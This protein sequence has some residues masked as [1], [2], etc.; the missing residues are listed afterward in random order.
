MIGTVAALGEGVSRD[1]HGK[2]LEVG[3][4]V[5]FGYFTHCGHCPGCLRGRHVACEHITMA[6]AG[7]AKAWPYFVGG[8]AD[9][10]YLQPGSPIYIVPEGLPDEVVAG[11]NCALSQVIY[12]LQRGALAFDETVVIQGAGGLGLYATA[13]AKAMGSGQVIVIDGVS[14]RLDLAL[15]FGADAV[16]DLREHKD[17]N[18]SAKAVR[19]LTAGRGADL[20]LELVGDPAVVPEGIRM[21]GQMG[22]Y[23]EIG[24]ISQGR[25]YEADPSRLVVANK[26]IIGVSLYE[27][28]ILGQA[29]HFLERMKDRLPLDALVSTRFSL[30]DINQAFAA[31]EAREVIRASIVP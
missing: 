1:A 22:R 11:A 25:T 27:P 4:R 3:S 24:N 31:A 9:Y 29:L 5:T 8:Y 15:R 2:P 28:H 23:V 6:M 10:F 14:S 7:K 16:V 13:V 26:S 30:F 19:A 17:S 20:V 18:A 12:G 21:L